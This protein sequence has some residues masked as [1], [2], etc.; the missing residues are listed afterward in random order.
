MTLH[1]QDLFFSKELKALE[2]VVL[3]LRGKGHFLPF[4][5]YEVLKGW[6]E[7]GTDKEDLVCKL[8][9]MLSVYLSKNPRVPLG[10]LDKRVR[11]NLA[12]IIRSGPE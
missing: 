1:Y 7:L 3:S 8:A 10:A 5:D 4:S 12:N 2:H 9:D 6:M 11:E